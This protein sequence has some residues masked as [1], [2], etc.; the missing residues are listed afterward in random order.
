MG[1]I[2][3]L[4]AIDK[5]LAQRMSFNGTKYLAII[6]LQGLNAP[7]G[8]LGLTYT[9]SH[10]TAQLDVVNLHKLLH[11]NAQKISTLLDDYNSKK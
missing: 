4:A 5:K 10:A 11:N 2:D 3:E 6:S 8:F 7:L 1:T 9:E